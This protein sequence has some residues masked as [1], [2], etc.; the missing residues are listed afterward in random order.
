MRVVAP[1]AATQ[2]ER[3]VFVDRA[4]L[5]GNPISFRVTSS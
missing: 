4:Q 1:R 2:I 5:L 3:N